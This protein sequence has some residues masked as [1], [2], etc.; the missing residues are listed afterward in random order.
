MQPTPSFSSLL[1]TVRAAEVF[2]D[3]DSPLADRLH[4][5]SNKQRM[6]DSKLALVVGNNSSGKSLLRRELQAACNDVDLETLDLSMEL[7]S[8]E[9]AELRGEYYGNEEILSTGV[10]SI[11]SVL[12]LIG[13]SKNEKR[14]HVII[15]DEPDVGLSDEV[16]A[17]VALELVSFLQEAPSKLVG[18][19]LITHRR[20]MLDCCY[21]ADPILLFVGPRAE[22]P[23][24]L[25]QWNSRKIVPQKPRA[26]IAAGVT[27]WTEMTTFDSLNRS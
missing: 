1:N 3:P 26:V 15:L 23:T 11:S 4:V 20:A 13:A 6:H 14:K 16:A 24:S 10:I 9:D 7:R 8:H 18:V 21:E 25:N 2:K 17:G 27:L 5:V 12:R 19:L 22:A